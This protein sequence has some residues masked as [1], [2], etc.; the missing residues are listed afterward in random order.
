MEPMPDRAADSHHARR[1]LIVRNP[2]AGR[3]RRSYLGLIIAELSRLGCSVRVIET[4]APGDARA[5]AATA[6]LE[7]CDV[8]A[9][10]GGDGTI[11]EVVNGLGPASPT[12]AVIPMGTANVL[13]RE[14]GL[15]RDPLQVAATIA[16]GL[17]R[18][19]HA[20]CLGDHRFLLMAG[21]GFDAA[22]VRAVGPAFK[23]RF[24]KG[25]YV[26]QTVLE[27]FRNR[28]PPI[29]VTVDG[30]RF[31]AIS[32]IV[33]NGRHYGGP[34]ISAPDAGLDRDRLDV[35]MFSRPGALNALRYA[36]ALVTDRLARLPDVR[37]AQGRVVRLD[38]R[39]GDPVQAD[40]DLLGRLPITA[41]LAGHVISLLYPTVT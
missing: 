19:V 3:R 17:P 22:V 32:V 7:F 36:T 33:A 11:N 23:R 24:G 14:I 25:A 10:A 31:E 41:T 4:G 20:A 21:A 5:I 6:S 1:V 39:R 37:I 2:A 18:P 30:R 27:L 28:Y 38:G 40:G 29:E 8:I 34:Y 35:V 12:I 13:A 26:I 16:S 9:I 15:R